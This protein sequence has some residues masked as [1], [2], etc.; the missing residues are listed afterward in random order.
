MPLRARLF[1]SHQFDEK[2]ALARQRLVKRQKHGVAHRLRASDRRLQS[3]GLC[4]HA[5]DARLKLIPIDT[6]ELVAPVAHGDERAALR[7][8]DRREGGGIGNQVDTGKAVDKT[9]L[10][11]LRGDN[12]H[13]GGDHIQAN[14]AASPGQQ[15]E[16]HFGQAEPGRLVGD[17]KMAAERQFQPTTQCRAMNGGDGRLFDRLQQR[18]QR[19]QVRILHRLAEFGDVGAGNESASCASDHDGGRRLVV[20]QP[21]ERIMERT[22]HGKRQR[23]HRRIV[24]GD[25]GDAAAMRDADLGL[26]CLDVGHRLASSNK[27]LKPDVA[28]SG[29]DHIYKP[30][31]R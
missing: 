15:A 17:P 4:R 31:G 30:A 2:G 6:F 11:G 21:G 16:L 1:G 22:A 19:S 3:P 9:S 25:D 26:G 28:A 23:I 18:D 24:D 5:L 8:L 12:R 27:A 10:Q 20:A 7:R 13:A 14:G 29:A